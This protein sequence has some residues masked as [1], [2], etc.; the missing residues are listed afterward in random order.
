MSMKAFQIIL[1]QKIVL[2]QK[3]SQVDNNEIVN[4]S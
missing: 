1:D 2:V 3:H 4:R